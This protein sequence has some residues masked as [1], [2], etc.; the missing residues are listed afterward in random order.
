[1]KFI[2]TLFV[3]LAFAITLTVAPVVQAAGP[4]TYYAQNHLIDYLFRGQA[5]GTP[6]TWYV[7]LYTV[8]P[9]DTAGS[10]TEVT[11]ANGYARVSV[12]TNALTNWNATQG[13]TSASSGTTGQ[14]S[15][16]SAISFATVTTASWGT[17]NCWALVDSGTYGGGNVWVYAPVTTPPTLTVGST[18]SFAA[19]A[20][21]VTI[22]P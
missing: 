9:T 3:L 21:T 12:G 10:G 20:L 4:F 22:T 8:C 15:N 6:S 1:M 18:A 19:G 16:I 11:N 7:A 5:S 13:G 2:R 17:I 14:T